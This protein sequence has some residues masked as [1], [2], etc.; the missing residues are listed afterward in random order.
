MVVEHRKISIVQKFNRHPRNK[1]VTICFVFDTACVTNCKECDFDSKKKELMECS[2]CD[3]GSEVTSEDI[4]FGTC[5]T[6]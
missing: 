5:V 6:M 2:T 4:C 3:V 1:F